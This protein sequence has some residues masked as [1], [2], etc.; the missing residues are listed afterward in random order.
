MT[1]C[2]QKV[3]ILDVA[4]QHFKRDIARCK[5]S[6]PQLWRLQEMPERAAADQNTISDGQVMK[7]Y[8]HVLDSG[9]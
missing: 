1:P 8:G 2:K 5:P 4:M 9:S 6:C 7:C 3:E